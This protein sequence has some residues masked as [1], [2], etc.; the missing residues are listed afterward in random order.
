LH[1][2]IVG[3]TQ[4]IEGL[5]S[6]DF[7]GGGGKEKS[8]PPIFSHTDGGGTSNFLHLRGLVGAY[9]MCEIDAPWIKRWVRGWLL[10]VSK[11][12]YGSIS[13]RA[14]PG[15]MHILQLRS[16]VRFIQNEGI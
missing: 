2:S 12:F 8:L 7:E 5:G 10:P 9:L 4:K 15:C 6:S 1:S 16:L 13:G 14:V 3:N 11:N